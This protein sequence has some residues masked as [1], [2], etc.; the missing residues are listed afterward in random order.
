MTEYTE[1]FVTAKMLLTITAES[2]E[3]AREIAETN[4]EEADFIACDEILEV[5]EN[6]E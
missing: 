4:P 2:E 3:Q 5:V 6:D 1:Y